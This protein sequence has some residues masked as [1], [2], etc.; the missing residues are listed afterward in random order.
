[1]ESNKDIL[2]DA[3]FK[4]QKL[5]EIAN[6]LNNDEL[7]SGDYSSRQIVL[8]SVVHSKNQFLFE[9]LEEALYDEN[10][11]DTL[12]TI[13]SGLLLNKKIIHPLAKYIDMT[14]DDDYLMDESFVKKE[15]LILAS[16]GIVIGIREKHACKDDCLKALE[17]IYIAA[18]KQDNDFPLADALLQRFINI[19]PGKS[20]DIDK[21]LLE[22]IKNKK[23]E[24]NPKLVAVEILA[25]S[26][27]LEFF[28]NI[29]D[30][31]YNIEEYTD[32]HVEILYMLDVTTKALS[33]FSNDIS[34]QEMR[35][36]V[37][38]LSVVDF[39]LKSEDEYAQ[40]IVARI[41]KRVDGIRNLLNSNN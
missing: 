29:R 13:V 34:N 31:I 32:S 40:T 9:I 8:S 14:I 33:A 3:K 21:M 12:K 15:G 24:L 25:R 22:V 16:E 6:E 1:M 36:L 11:Q 7:E 37:D 20:E 4:F 27:G 23:M 10:Y 41:K 28:S 38:F 17:K 2:E 39:K 5:C 19:L 30:I 18:C 35:E 26:M